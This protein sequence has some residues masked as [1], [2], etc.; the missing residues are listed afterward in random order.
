M[1]WVLHGFTISFRAAQANLQHRSKSHF[2]PT[3]VKR[4]STGND[5]SNKS[6]TCWA[7]KGS[8]AI[9]HCDPLVGRKGQAVG[10][11]M[12]KSLCRCLGRCVSLVNLPSSLQT[13]QGFSGGFNLMNALLTPIQPSLWYIF[14][15]QKGISY[16][17]RII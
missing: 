3:E 2:Q 15:G 13:L 16:T 9:P 1:M 4:S 7:M 11:L 14:P 17:G 8:F 12:M 5:A 10:Y 6:G